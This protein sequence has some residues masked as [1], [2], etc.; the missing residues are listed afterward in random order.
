MCFYYKDK[1]RF[2]HLLYRQY[3]AVKTI[4]A[5]SLFFERLRKAPSMDNVLFQT[6]SYASIIK[7]INAWLK[8]Q[9]H[10]LVFLSNGLIIFSFLFFLEPR[11][12][13]KE[14]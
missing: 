11:H 4:I 14:D 12:A 3:N 6:V 7:D 13:Y 9:F 2:F 10:I 1:I 5:A 8:L